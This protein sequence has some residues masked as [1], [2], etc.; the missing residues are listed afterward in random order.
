MPAGLIWAVTGDVTLLMTFVAKLAG[1]LLLWAFPVLEVSWCSK[2]FKETYRK[3]S[4]V[5][6]V[7]T[8]LLST[9]SLDAVAMYTGQYRG[10][11]W[12]L[13]TYRLI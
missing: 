11:P 7:V 12:A 8:F 9:L 5:A 13:R 1:G 4:K 6:T 10:L 2:W 3:V